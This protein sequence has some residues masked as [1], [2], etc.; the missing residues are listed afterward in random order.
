M[1]AV[2][3]AMVTRVNEAEVGEKFLQHTFFCDRGEQRA[4]V[5]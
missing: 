3:A 2:P 4:S 5:Q 1:Q